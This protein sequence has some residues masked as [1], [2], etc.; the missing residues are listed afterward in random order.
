MIVDPGADT[1]RGFGLAEVLMAIAILGIGILAVAGLVSSAAERTRAAQRLTDRAFVAQQELE[2]AYLTPFDS[3]VSATDTI[4]GSPAYVIDRSV[5]L[6]GT[7]LKRVDVSVSD[8]A[9]LLPFRLSTVIA[10][11][12]WLP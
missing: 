5:S 11:P 2:T 12:T 4:A 10:R 8:S 9:S 6:V 7:R 3:L 1:R